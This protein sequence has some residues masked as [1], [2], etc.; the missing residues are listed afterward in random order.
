MRPPGRSSVHR[1]REGLA[2]HAVDDHVG[3][4]A[5]GEREDPFAQSWRA[6]VGPALR[7]ELTG[8]GELGVAAGGHQHAGAPRAAICSAN[9]DTPPPMPVTSTVSPARTWARLTTAR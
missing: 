1:A 6:V 9:V 7:A 4:A 2:A 8:P 3:P 5:A